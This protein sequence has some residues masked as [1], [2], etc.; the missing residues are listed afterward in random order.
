MPGAGSAAKEG[1]PFKVFGVDGEE[2]KDGA[3]DILCGARSGA[4][5]GALTMG[6]SMRSGAPRAGVR[7]HGCKGACGARVSLRRRGSEGTVVGAQVSG[8]VQAKVGDTADAMMSLH[9]T[10]GAVSGGHDIPEDVIA[11]ECWAGGWKSRIVFNCVL[12]MS[13]RSRAGIFCGQFFSW[14]W[15]MLVYSRQRRG[16]ILAGCTDNVAT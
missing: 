1:M 9:E 10:Q 2:E 11:R 3:E 5:Q 14:W 4:G 12:D 7:T 15:C 6:C 8:G 16:E 13:K